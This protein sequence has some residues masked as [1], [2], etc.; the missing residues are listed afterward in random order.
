MTQ[1]GDTANSLNVDIIGGHTEITAAVN[2]FV[3]ITTSIGRVLKDKL[4]TTSGAQVGDDIVLTKSAGIEGTAIIAFDKEWELVEGIGCESVERAKG[5]M[6]SISVVKEGK[7]AGDFGVSAMHDV[8]EG[9]VLGAVW[10]LAEA[11]GVGVE[12]I[13]DRIPVARETEEICKFYGINPLKL[14]SSGCMVIACEDGQ[15]LVEKLEENGI[16]ASVIGKVTG[17]VERKLISG[18]SIEDIEQPESDELYK[19][20]G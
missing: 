9:G 5:Y 6:D 11:S 13:E 12:V 3:V 17:G 4:V 2:K 19:V 14:I 18:E 8:T 1:M 16:K 15:A 10:E 20:V 7:L